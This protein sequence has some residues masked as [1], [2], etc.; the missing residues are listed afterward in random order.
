MEKRRIL[1]STPVR[2]G[3]SPR[4]LAGFIQVMKKH[5]PELDISHIFHSGTSV[6][7]ARNEI[8]HYAIATDVREIV[9]ID[10]DMAWDITYWDRLISHVDLDIVA[11]LYCKK[12]PGPPFWLTNLAEGKEIDPKTGVCEV[13]EI[14]TGFM[15]IRV[16]TVLKRMQEEYPEREYYAKFK[17]EGEKGPGDDGTAFEFFPMG[18]MGPRSP[19]ARLLRIKEILSRPLPADDSD[20]GLHMLSLRLQEIEDACY[21]AQPPGNLFGED[22][23]FCRAA[24]ACGFKIHCD[25]GMPP[26]GH[27]GPATY[28]ITP[29]MVGLDPDKTEVVT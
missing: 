6:N 18:V 21:D 5:Q 16:D 8:C 17:K 1:I 11:G 24:R 20:R 10:D 4:Y 29:A 13:D 19:G 15:K 25:F 14:A 12:V 23:Y 22:Y 9:F 7:F 3:I 28:P 2:G 26:V 27:I